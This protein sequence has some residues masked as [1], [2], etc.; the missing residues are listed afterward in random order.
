MDLRKEKNFLARVFCPQLK[1]QMSQ[2]GYVTDWNVTRRDAQ[3]RGEMTQGQL[4]FQVDGKPESASQVTGRQGPITSGSPLVPW[5]KSVSFP[6]SSL[7]ARMTPQKG[8]GQT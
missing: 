2:M 3:A 5:G 4:Q 1:G 8:W 7:E 6:K